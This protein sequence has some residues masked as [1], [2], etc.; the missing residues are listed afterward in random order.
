MVSLLIVVDKICYKSEIL[1]RRDWEKRQKLIIS[2]GCWEFEKFLGDD[3]GIGINSIV[4]W[5][6][7]NSS[8]VKV[9]N[10]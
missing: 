6:M 7:V 3:D 4:G 10:H 5:D 2:Y 1:I 9:K 8:L